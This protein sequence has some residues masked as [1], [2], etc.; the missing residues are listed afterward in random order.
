[1][2]NESIKLDSWQIGAR[3]DK[4]AVSK[5]SSSFP[6]ICYP[7]LETTPSFCIQNEQLNKL[8]K[9]LGIASVT[10][11]VSLFLV[12]VL[13]Q[14]NKAESALLLYTYILTAWRPRQFSLIFNFFSDF[15]PKNSLQINKTHTFGKNYIF[16][17]FH[18]SAQFYHWTCLLCSLCT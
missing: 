17:L 6:S 14:V 11:N 16:K 8:D 10:M 7:V 15:R 3:N 5:Q 4:N 18:E 2:N 13:T 12:S 1:M 9:W